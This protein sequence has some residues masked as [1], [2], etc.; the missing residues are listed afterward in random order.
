V[1]AS[2]FLFATSAFDS[3]CATAHNISLSSI[4]SHTDQN[5][6]T[7]GNWRKKI[8]ERNNRTPFLGRTHHFCLSSQ[9]KKTE[10][11]LMPTPL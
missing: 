2:Q 3:S 11:K 7:T 1:A 8:F 6:G 10:I 5:G 4:Q 9:R